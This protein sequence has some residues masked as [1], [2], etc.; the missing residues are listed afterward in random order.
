MDWMIVASI[1]GGLGAMTVAVGWARAWLRVRNDLRYETGVDRV[2]RSLP[3]AWWIVHRAG[4]DVGLDNLRGVTPSQVNSLLAPYLD[5]PVELHQVHRR[6]D[7]LDEKLRHLLVSHQSLPPTARAFDVAAISLGGAVAASDVETLTALLDS[8][9]EVAGVLAEAKLGAL[10]DILPD[11]TAGVLGGAVDASVGAIGDPLLNALDSGVL[12]VPVGSMVAGGRRLHKGVQ[13]G[14][15]SER[16]AENAALDVGVQGGGTVAGAAL[17]TF[18]IPIPVLGTVLGS[19]VG[20]VVGSTVAGVARGRHLARARAKWIES[21]ETFGGGVSR[22]DFDHLNDTMDRSLEAKERALAA[23]LTATRTRPRSWWPSYQ[24]GF[25][26]QLLMVA[27]RDVEQSRVARQNV[28]ES[29]RLMGRAPLEIRGLFWLRCGKSKRA[30]STSPLLEAAVA[31][32][33][34][35]ITARALG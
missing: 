24:R 16:I 1:V 25:V 18:L 13:L 28:Q 20:G 14:V 31:Y 33:H 35:H 21:L 11:A 15:S 12:P 19:M 34:E 27:R 2:R 3:E 9:G 22:V 5:E 26:R 32:H 17:G 8:A 30:R 23:L 29:V 7:E 10:G 6:A 4:T